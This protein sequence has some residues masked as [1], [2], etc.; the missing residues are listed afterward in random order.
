M[1]KSHLVSVI[2]PAFN[3]GKYLP[4]TLKSVQM[5]SY[6]HLEVIVVDDGSTDG[7][8]L[9]AQKLFGD[10]VRFRFYFQPNKGAAAAR[11]F[12]FLQSKGNYIKFLDADDLLNP[13]AI[14]DQ[15]LL[16]EKNPDAIISGKW[17]RFYN[18]DLTTFKLNSESVWRNMNGKD[19]I[20][21]SWLNGPNM[22]QSGIFLLPRKC[23]EQYGLWDERLSLM[24]DCQF[25]TNLIVRSEI[26]FCETS[27]LYYRS[28]LKNNLSGR[29][30]R[31][32]MESAFLTTDIAVRHL[33]AAE[34][35]ERSRR[36][37]AHLFQHIAF[38]CYPA[39]P[40]LTDRA[41]AEVKL[42]GGTNYRLPSG[43]L[44]K[45][46]EPLLG[47]KIAKRIQIGF[48]TLKRRLTH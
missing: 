28:G 20:I 25:F 40:D 23:I 42:L 11:N 30:N 43:R 8:T 26:V 9:I 41:E 3:S 21:E 13:E 15:M 47:W 36:A 2:I 35:S 34:N 33:L 32:S 27:I 46:I 38:E 31:K 44:G 1:E 22:T 19:W 10:D 37:A 48:S 6:Q 4:E 18:D 29:K 45:I 12:G 24:D 39:Y 16:K 14:A 17:G 5:Q 7:S